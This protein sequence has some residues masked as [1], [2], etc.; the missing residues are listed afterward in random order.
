MNFIKIILIVTFVAI[1]SACSGFKGE[2]AF[3][4]PHPQ[5]ISSHRVTQDNRNVT[6]KEARWLLNG[7]EDPYPTQFLT[8]LDDPTGKTYIRIDDLVDAMQTK[9]E[10]IKYR[11]SQVTVSR[12]SNDG[13]RMA[14]V[15]TIS[16]VEE[17][18]EKH[19][20]EVYDL[21]SGKKE[22]EFELPSTSYPVVSPDL[23]KYLYELNGQ[24]YLYD[25]VKRKTTKI[26]IG[27][28]KID[29]G[30]ISSGLFSPDGTR[31][32]FEENDQ[33]GIIMLN[34]SGISGIKRLLTGSMVS[35]LQWD[36]ED[37]LIY[38]ISEEDDNYTKDVYSFDI[39]SGEKRW[40]TK[41]TAPFILS[42]DQK[43][44]LSA[45]YEAS[46][47][48]LV[49]LSDGR[50]EDISSFTKNQGIRTAPIQWIEAKTNYMK[51]S[52]KVKVKRITA[53]STLPDQGIRSFNVDNLTDGNYS[54]SWCE[55]T[56]GGGVGETVTI[57]LGSTQEMRGIDI[58]DNF[59]WV[60]NKYLDV[61]KIKKMKLDF[62]NGQ[63]EV[64]EGSGARFKFDEPI[65]TS[66]VKITILEVKKGADF[67][68][69]CIGELKLL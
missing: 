5:E 67:P 68:N 15:R 49:H 43:L 26:D 30:I 29:L 14:I 69:T 22:S 60:N 50:K 19:I 2:E 64:F 17:G 32:C 54:T 59:M 27:K 37:K 44:A 56:K 33:P 62:S 39:E 61:S 12:V 47:M 42:P 58:T 40:I 36:Q 41:S 1:I 16:D 4:S 8:N 66:F 63:S 35:L 51:Y 6:E 48:Y 3:S 38:T 55:G 34:L 23:S 31:F 21:N 24:V 53:S 11:G 52:N 28:R 45:E 13:S 57:D 18:G 46:K 25:A 9:E 10:R 65:R 20:L 7:E